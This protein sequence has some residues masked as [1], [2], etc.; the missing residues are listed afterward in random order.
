[1]AKKVAPKIIKNKIKSS[2]R[3]IFMFDNHFI[4]LLMPVI[5]DTQEILMIRIK[6]DI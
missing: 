1:M 4:P 3:L 5:A 2:D 6:P